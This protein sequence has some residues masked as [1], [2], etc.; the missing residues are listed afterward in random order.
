[1]ISTIVLIAPIFLFALCVHEYSHAWVAVKLGDNTAK[2][3][4]RLTLNPIAHADLIG[5]VILPI[6]CIVTGGLFFA[7]AKPVPVDMR[8]L[9]RGLK[10]MA[11]VAAAGPASNVVLALASTLVL[12]LLSSISMSPE[13][14]NTIGQFFSYAIYIN[15]ILAIF[16]LL[17]IPPLDGYRIV[18]GMVPNALAIKIQKLEP[19]GGILLL[20]LLFTGSLGIIFGPVQFCTRFLLSIAGTVAESVI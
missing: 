7:W 10:D 15:V 19:L 8:N 4:G 13:W 5:T 2:D 11:L 18:Q 16:N 1:M 6:I 17:P 20:V 9:K 12:G 3:M 14:A